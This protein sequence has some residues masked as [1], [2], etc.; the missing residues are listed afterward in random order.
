MIINILLGL[1][2]VLIVFAIIVALQPSEFSVTRTG[3]V[4]AP[5]EAVFPQVNDLH[6]WEAWNPWTKLDP[7]LK[8]T[9]Q[10][11][12]SGIGASYSWAGNSKVGEGRMTITESRPSELIQ[13]KLEFLKPFAATNTAEFAFKPDGNQTAVTWT[14]SGK[15]NFF[16]KAV[17]LLISMDKMIGG[18]FEDG[19]AKMKSV[20]EAAMKSK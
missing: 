15:K 12:S 5:P 11:P 6:K 7:A 17:G 14:M 2:V 3:R 9:Y 8:Q 16:T 19:L 13:L 18:Q 20:T 10:G 1:A 4:A